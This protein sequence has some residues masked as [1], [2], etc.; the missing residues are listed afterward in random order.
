MPLLYHYIKCFSSDITIKEQRGYFEVP[1]F[2]TFPF[3]TDP[4]FTLFLISCGCLVRIGVLVADWFVSNVTWLWR[5]RE[6]R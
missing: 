4:F 6:K 3:F 1:F 2:E 5:H